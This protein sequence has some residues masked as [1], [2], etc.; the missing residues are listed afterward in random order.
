MEHVLDR[1]SRL[2][3]NDA[4]VA[5]DVMDGE[6]IMIDLANGTYYSMDNVGGHIWSLIRDGRSLEE[7]VADVT[8]RYAVD[9]T[10]ARRDVRRLTEQ[11]LDER[12]VL[13]ADGGAA[14]EA[15]A[16]APLAE[17]LAYEPPRLTVHRDMERL[18]ALDPPMPTLGEVPWKP[19]SSQDRT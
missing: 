9:P 10:E 19:A 7:I 11:L 12:L 16:A 4:Q 5:S 13:P 3:P 14:G 15:S 6:A 18:L 2:R 17:K 8:A 1:T